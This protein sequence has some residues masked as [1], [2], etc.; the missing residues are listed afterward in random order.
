MT[1]PVVE[2]TVET[3]E[4]DTAETPT[5]SVPAE[6]VQVKLPEVAADPIASQIYDQ[7]ALTIPEFN[8]VN[9]QVKGTQGTPLEIDAALAE[10]YTDNGGEYDTTNAK[11]EQLLAALEKVEDMLTKMRAAQVQK[12]VSEGATAI[13]PLL[14]QADKLGKSIKT[15]ENYLKALAAQNGWGDPLAGLPDVKRTRKSGGT[16]KTD[17]EPSVR[18][19]GYDYYVNGQLAFI[20]TQKDGKEIN[21]SSTSAVAKV[22]GAPTSDCQEAFW[23]AQGTKV[24]ADF[25]P[26]VTY[27]QIV[28]DKTYSILARKH[29]DPATSVDV[30]AGQ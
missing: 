16:S 2:D 21:R 26:E 12:I 11:R 20:S 28:G 4:P 1:A 25:K 29:V 6:P 15:G 22:I 18:I 30:Q 3:A 8:A 17:G 5:E 23:A 24:A 27:N 19:R 13:Q 14:D 10:S 7:L 9:A